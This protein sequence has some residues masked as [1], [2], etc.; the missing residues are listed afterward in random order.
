MV[1]LVKP[2]LLLNLQYLA[3]KSI[4]SAGIHDGL[5]IISVVNLFEAKYPDIVRYYS[6]FL[7]IFRMC[8]KF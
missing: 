5:T 8:T 6:K 2:W 7:F 4:K 1:L 3:Y